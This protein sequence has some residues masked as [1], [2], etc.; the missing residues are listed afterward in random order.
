MKKLIFK[1]LNADVHKTLLL[2]DESTN[3]ENSRENYP[4]I[5]FDR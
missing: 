1:I 5:L 2:V 3:P 4:V